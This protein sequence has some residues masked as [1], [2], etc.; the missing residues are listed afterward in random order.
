MTDR[1]ARI[2]FRRLTRDDFPQL[3]AWLSDPDVSPWYTADELSPDGMEAE[4]GDIIDGTDPVDSYIVLIDGV[5]AGYIQSYRLGD[6]PDYLAQLD[7]DPDYVSTDLFLG[8]PA[9]R[10]HGWGTPLLRAFLREKIFGELG[11]TRASIMPNPK[12]ARA[13]KVYERAGFK[14]VRSLPIR[15]THTGK[16]EDELIMLL[17]SDNFLAANQCP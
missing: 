17:S 6:H 8:N 1:E 9:Y 7:L 12:N 11:A 5:E 16:I 13:I 3:L 4:F 14:P 2:A 15:D 10:N